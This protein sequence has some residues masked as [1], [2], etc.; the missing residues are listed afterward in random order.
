MIFFPGDQVR[1]VRLGGYPITGVI[2]SFTYDVPA[3]MRGECNDAASI[4]VTADAGLYV[5][6]DLITVPVAELEP[7]AS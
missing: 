6:G 1:T 2:K 7:A 3:L 4:I 5:A